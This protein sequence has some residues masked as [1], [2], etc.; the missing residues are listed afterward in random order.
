MSERI[1]VI[2]CGSIGKRHIRNLQTLGVKIILGYDPRED[3]CEE[4]RAKFQIETAK[5]IEEVWAWE[6]N[7]ALVTTPTSLHAS[8]ALAAAKHHCH[9]FIEKPLSDALSAELRELLTRVREYDLVTWVGCNFRFQPALERVK[10]LLDQRV[11]GRVVAIRAEAG[12][13]LPDW[14]PWEDYRLSYSARRELGGGVILDAIHELDYLYWMLGD[15]ESVVCFAGHL[16][17]L[18]MDTEDTAAILLR[19]LDGTIGEVHLDYIQRSYSRTAHFIG[20]EGTI[21]WDFE[22]GLT[23]WY[24][25]ATQKWN[26]YRQPSHWQINQMY[27]DEMVHFLRAIRREVPAMLDVT[28]AL[29]VLEIALAAKTSAATGQVVNMRQNP[30]L[31]GSAA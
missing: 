2:G 22:S 4:V 26:E 31:V 3:R 27:L 5:S 18:S 24:T 25:A 8:L 20:E 16:S 6:P 19:F 30:L 17:Q 13:Y 23:R 29:R 12:Q 10:G 15:V 21:R 11:I 1:V 9:L 28:E 7:V 14:H